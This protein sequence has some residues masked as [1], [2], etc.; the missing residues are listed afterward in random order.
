MDSTNEAGSNP[1][2]NADVRVE[3]RVYKYGVHNNI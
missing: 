3:Q 1:Q 2:R